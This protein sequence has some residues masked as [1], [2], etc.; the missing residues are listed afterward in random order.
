M[1]WGIRNGS[2]ICMWDFYSKITSFRAVLTK[3]AVSLI[4]VVQ[5]A[6]PK[7]LHQLY[8]LAKSSL[9]VCCLKDYPLKSSYYSQLSQTMK[10]H[11]YFPLDSNSAETLRLCLLYWIIE[12]YFFCFYNN[13]SHTKSLSGTTWKHSLQLI[14]FPN[15]SQVQTA[16]SSWKQWRL[17]RH[18]PGIE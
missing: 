3:N 2:I 15:W 4:L 12:L 8:G 7:K 9:C 14:V 17:Y 16:K 5:Y 18:I 10:Q 11:K 6:I 13:K 1:R